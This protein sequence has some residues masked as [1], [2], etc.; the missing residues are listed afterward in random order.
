MNE[1][2]HIQTSS[3]SCID[4]IFTDQPKISVNS[5]VHASSH[6]NCHH[7]IVHSSLNLNT[8]YSPSY[9]RLIWDYKKADSKNIRTALDLVNWERLIDQRNINAQAVTFDETIL[10]VF[11]NYVPNNYVTIDDK[12]FVWM[13]ETIKSKSDFVYL[14]NLVIEI[15]ELISS[16]KASCYKNL[17]KKLNNPLL[18][19]KTYWSIL[20]AFSHNDKKIPL[21]SPLLV[22]K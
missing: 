21:I 12:D 4:L 16:T 9:Q 1:L 11:R 13:N 6:P 3:S 20:K 17:A 5:G 15:N 2:T 14:E 22:C 18:Q 10:N 19:A 8:Y 7:Q